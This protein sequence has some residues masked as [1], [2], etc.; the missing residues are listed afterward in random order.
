MDIIKLIGFI[1]FII[2]AILIFWRIKDTEGFYSHC[3]LL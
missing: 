3:Y 1:V 2:V